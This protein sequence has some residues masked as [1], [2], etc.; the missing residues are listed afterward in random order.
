MKDVCIAIGIG[1]PI[2]TIN[3]VKR[4]FTSIQKCI[5]NCTWKVLICLGPNVN[6]KVTHFVENF[7][8]S[9]SNNFEII[10]RDEVTFS[11]FVNQAIKQSEDYEY[12]IKSH[13]DIELFTPDFFPTAMKAIKKIRKEVGW[14]S[15]TDIGWKRG[16]LNHS[17][18]GSYFKDIIFD[19]QKQKEGTIFQ[20][21][22][23]PPYWWI[24]PGPLH[25]LQRATNK[26][27]AMLKLPKPPYPRPLKKISKMKIDLPQ[28]PVLCHAPFGHFIMIKRA[29][30]VDKIGLCEEWN[31]K[32]GLL[33][34]EDWGLTMLKENIPNIWIPTLEYLHKRIE[35]EACGGT[36]SWPEIS[37]TA[38]IV[39]Q[40]FFEKWGFH[41]EPISPEELTFIQKKYKDTLIPWS[42]Y[43]NS[44]EWDY[45]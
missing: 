13:D 14:I 32:G 36:R 18:R 5:G 20:F 1:S 39:S 30:F 26:I 34:D 15:F 28:T 7:V 2:S 45:I 31:T 38:S 35:S 33:I 27:C 17:V 9:H 44:Y 37:K 4:T 12:F 25:F 41:S 24:A 43:R 21:H 3:N 23:C 6:K 42:S 40:K 8:H 29:T 19:N 10:I 11:T 16:Y 22:N